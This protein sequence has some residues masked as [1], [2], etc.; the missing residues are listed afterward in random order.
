MNYEQWVK[1]LY[2]R[3][4]NDKEHNQRHTTAA[5]AAINE[6]CN[7]QSVADIELQNR[8]NDELDLI[9]QGGF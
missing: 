5:L 7:S 4:E 3:L 1:D 6:G 8:L 2:D 9:I